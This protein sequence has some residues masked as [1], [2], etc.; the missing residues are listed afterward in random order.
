M[1]NGEVSTLTTM[2]APQKSDRLTREQIDAVIEAMSADDV[3][4]AMGD[5]ETIKGAKM[6]GDAFNSA[7]ARIGMSNGTPAT[8][9]VSLRDFKYLADA[10]GKAVNVENPL[11]EGQED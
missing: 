6:A 1:R 2:D 10:I 3:I 7:A 9:H 11:S 4:T 5:G 8:Q